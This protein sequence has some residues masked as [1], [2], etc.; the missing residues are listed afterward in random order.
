M[1]VVTIRTASGTQAARLMDDRVVELDGYADVKALLGTGEGWQERATASGGAEHGLDEVE[2]AP[3][4]PKPDKVICL[5]LNYL[6]HVKETG[7]DVPTHPTLFAKYARALIGPRDDIV[8]P[9]SS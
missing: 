6:S 7:R 9:A 2:L 3:V 1:R 5:G 8:L 4:V